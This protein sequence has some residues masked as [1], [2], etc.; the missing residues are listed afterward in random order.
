MLR[1]RPIFE[2]KIKFGLLIKDNVVQL[3]NFN[4]IKNFKNGTKIIFIR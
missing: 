2:C 4:Q 1:V 3:Y